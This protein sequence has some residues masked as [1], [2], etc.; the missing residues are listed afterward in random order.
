M[1]QFQFSSQN[2]NKHYE[3]VTRISEASVEE[4]IPNHMTGSSAALNKT[5]ESIPKSNY[6]KQTIQ[7]G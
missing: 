4:D 1:M 7:E 3:K 5:H 2:G 6:L